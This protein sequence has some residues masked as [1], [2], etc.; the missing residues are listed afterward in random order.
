MASQMCQK[1]SFRFRRAIM[2]YDVINEN[3]DV[4]GFFLQ[5]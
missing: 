3:V 2:N 4:C 1:L 5:Q